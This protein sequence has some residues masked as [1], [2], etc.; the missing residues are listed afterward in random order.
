MKFRRILFSLIR[1]C[2]CSGLCPISVY[3]SNVNS[4]N[5]KTKIGFAALTA[6][7]FIVQLLDS[8]HFFTH[9]DYYL[10]WS[11][12]AV[13]SLIF[14][15]VS[16]TLRLHA[17]AVLI[18]SYAKRSIQL[19]VLEKLD[20]I[21]QIFV[22]KLK[23][24]T[25]DDRLRKRCCQFINGWIVKVSGFIAIVFFAGVSLLRW[26]ILYQLVM[27]IPP[28]YTYT[29]FYVQ[30]MVYLDM[31]KY[32]I[33]AINN[34]LIAMKKQLRI[35]PCHRKSHAIISTITCQQLIN[36]RS[37]YCKTWEASLLINR[38]VRWSLLFGATNDFVLYVSNLYWIL[39]I[40][41]K[42]T[43]GKWVSLL[44]FVLWISIDMSHFVLISRICEQIAGEVSE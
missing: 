24:K 9:T 15:F 30:L 26:D 23:F 25:N 18:E 13:L 33:E 1:L 35:H 41:F 38:W 2:Q 29:L 19:E 5:A 4:A 32:N 14:L 16:F 40:L 6:I 31:I 3:G 8:V 20:E 7:I 28:F 17:V 27:T 21:E 42:S 34:C 43:E 12:S 44:V 36:L 37:C 39:F 11:I 10:D 22:H